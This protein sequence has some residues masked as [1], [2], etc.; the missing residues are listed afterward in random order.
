MKVKTLGHVYMTAGGIF[1]DVNSPHEHATETLLFGLDAIVEVQ[2]FNKE[3]GFTFAVCAGQHLGGPVFIGM[4]GQTL[5][6]KTRPPIDEIIRPTFEIIGPPVRTAKVVISRPVYLLDN[7]SQFRIVERSAVVGE[8]ANA[9]EET[10]Y[11]VS[12]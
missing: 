7:R 11:V 2:R 8:T 10:L 9:A 12:V 5:A 4:I 3:R 6:G 1:C